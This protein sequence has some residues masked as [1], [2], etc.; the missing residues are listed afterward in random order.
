MHYF[1]RIEVMQS[2]NGIFVSQKKYVREILDRIQKEDCN[3]VN[4]PTV[5]GLKLDKD[6][7]GN[8]MDNTLYKQI[9]GNKMY[10]SATRQT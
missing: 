2:T 5:F 1:V 9:V 10:L 3:P 7:E 8:K 4:T 6:H